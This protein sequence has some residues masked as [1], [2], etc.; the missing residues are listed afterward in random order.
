MRFSEQWLREWI[1]PAVDTATLAHRL[2]MAGLEVD[3]IEPA[4]P[5][6]TGIVVG[7]VLSVARHPEADK[8]NITRVT[9]GD[10]EYQVVCGAPN[11]QAGMR[12]PFARIGAVLPGGMTIQQAKL[13][14]VASSGM[15]CSATELG[16]PSDLDGLWALPED[17]PVGADIRA[18]LKLDDSVIELGITPN[19][20]DALSILGLARE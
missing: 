16:L 13:R 14:G 17:A 10:A 15:L 18:W 5:A 2:T 1:D 12:V 19:R 3:A 20:G 6:F 7:E 11:V 8:L 4:A 9:D